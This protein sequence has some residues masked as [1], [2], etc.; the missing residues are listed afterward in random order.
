MLASV[1]YT[2]H[3][4]ICWTPSLSAYVE[5]DEGWIPINHTNIQVIDSDSSDMMTSDNSNIVLSKA[6]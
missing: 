4:P 1:N 2:V 3:I 6:V 5:I